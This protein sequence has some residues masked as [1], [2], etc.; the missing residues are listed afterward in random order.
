MCWLF[1]VLVDW[2]LSLGPKI[3]VHKTILTSVFSCS[4]ELW[5]WNHTVT[6]KLSVTVQSANGSYHC[7]L[8]FVH[9]NSYSSQRTKNSKYTNAISVHTIEHRN[10]H[11][12]HSSKLVKQL[13]KW[14]TLDQWGSGSWLKCWMWWTSLGYTNLKWMLLN[15]WMLL[16]YS[17]LSNTVY[18]VREGKEN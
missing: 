5:K 4:L 7:E 12:R 8:S 18:I 13:I 16:F 9:L 17:L 11:L 2:R 10:W 15:Y 14:Q 6:L 1:I 3:L